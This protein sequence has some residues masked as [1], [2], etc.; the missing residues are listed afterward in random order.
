MLAL[1]V[2]LLKL[3]RTWPNPP[4]V[5]LASLEPSGMFDSK[6]NEMWLVSFN[7]IN[8]NSLGEPDGIASSLYVKHDGK[9]PE[10]RVGGRWSVAEEPSMVLAKG[11]SSV[12]VCESTLR[13][14]IASSVQCRCLPTE[15]KL[16]NAS[17]T[18]IVEK[19]GGLGWVSAAGEHPL[20]DAIQV[21]EMGRLPAPRAFVPMERSQCG[22]TGAKI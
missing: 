17:C 22:I 11:S 12:I 18:K 13:G 16:C 6:G 14:P 8:T 10:V 19:H 1:L 3:G 7:I 20:S 15:T 4:D 2:V 9:A 5:R 21:L